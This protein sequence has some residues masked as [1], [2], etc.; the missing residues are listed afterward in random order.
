MGTTIRPAVLLPD[1]DEIAAVGRVGCHPRLNFSIHVVSARLTVVR[2]TG[3]GAWGGDKYNG[4][5]LCLANGG[6]GQDSQQCYEWCKYKLNLLDVM[7][8]MLLLVN[9]DL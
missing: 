6:S 2:T 8:P 4:D 1:A 3:I 5:C 7:H 9:F